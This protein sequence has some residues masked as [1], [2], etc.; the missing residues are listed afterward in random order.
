[1]IKS[2]YGYTSK[3][4]VRIYGDLDKWLLA[5]RNNVKPKTRNAKKFSK[6]KSKPKT[7]CWKRANEFQSR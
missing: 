5:K 3:E 4:E 2:K 1:M 6:T 7:R